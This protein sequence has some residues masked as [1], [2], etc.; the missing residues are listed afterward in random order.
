MSG[1]AHRLSSTALAPGAT[2]LLVMSPMATMRWRQG[3]FQLSSPRYPKNVVI[4][5]ALVP[6]LLELVEPRAA[7][8]ILNRQ[9]TISR[10]DCRDVLAIL[11]D[12]GIVEVTKPPSG[13][14]GKI[15]WD[16][17]DRARYDA[18][19]LE[20][21]QIAHGFTRSAD[22]R[23]SVDHWGR[24]LPRIARPVIDFLFQLDLSLL[25]V[26]EYG[27]GA[28]TFY[29]DRRCAALVTA[30]SDDEWAN[31][32]VRGVGPKSRILYRPE[33]QAFEEAILETDD[34]YDI[35]LIDAAPRFRSG[36]VGPALKRLRG[37][38]MIILDDAPL[39]PCAAESLRRAGLIEIDVTG[40]SSL[41]DNLQTTSLF[42]SREFDLPRRTA[43]GP[44]FPFG[45]PGFDWKTFA[46]KD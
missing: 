12:L 16:P 42:L 33:R 20:L 25:S 5:A 21:I 45:S 35:I 22:E 23:F 44:A 27:G 14:G 26:F 19:A 37:R 28:S 32:L 34:C 7:S 15:W 10:A 18:V 8:W 30:E 38:G 29:W 6:V 11:I 17:D 2:E 4:D 3:Q 9:W 31:R 24:P 41:E 46:A 40:F 43:C 39:Y 13:I 36:C 1:P